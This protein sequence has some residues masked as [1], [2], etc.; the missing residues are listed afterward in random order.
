MTIRVWAALALGGALVSCGK[1]AT[2]SGAAHSLTV[3]VRDNAF[4]PKVDSISVGDSVTFIWQGSQL[5]DLVFQDSTVG[6][7]SSPQSTG[8]IK[9]GFTAP[10]IY[11]Y[12]CTLHSTDFNT[13]EMIGTI[14][15]Y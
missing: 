7:V 13:G 6:N 9:R 5:H 8:S 10:G 2:A 3:S 1:S 12:R 4:S 15:A 11:L 14:A